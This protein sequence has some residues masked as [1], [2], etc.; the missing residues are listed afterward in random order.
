MKLKMKQ[1]RYAGMVVVLVLLSAVFFS[2]ED[3]N[4]LV[5]YADNNLITYVLA[6][7]FNLGLFYTAVTRSGRDGL[8]TEPGP[9]TVLA[10]SDDAFNTYGYNTEEAVMTIGQQRVTQLTDYHILSG[11]YRLDQLPFL[12]NQQLETMDGG[13]LFVTHWVKGQDT[14]ITVNGSRLVAQNIEASNGLIHVIDRVLEPYVHDNLADGIAA[15]EEL[16]LFYQALKSSGSLDLLKQSGTYYTVFAP[17]N[18]AMI[19][20]GYATLE[21][22]GNT[23]PEEL[24]ALVRYQVVTD[25]RFI[26]DYILT[27]GESGTSR[28]TMLD[29]NPVTVTLVPD[30]YT[31]G[32]YT[33][34]TLRGVGNSSEVHVSQDIYTGN[35]VL[36]ITDQVLKINQ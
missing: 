32:S 25:I 8:L 19:S 9:F 29:G 23:D 36:H 10:P 35:G 12:F 5:H 18:T 34:I 33:G 6:D 2:C 15:E 11:T 27:T 30:Y 20:A 26:Y 3:D 28:Q 21:Q 4:S 1:K 24:S 16:T 31:P 22:I 14:V 7:N 17:S 13:K